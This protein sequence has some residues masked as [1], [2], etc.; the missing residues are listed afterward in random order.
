MR[1]DGKV[2]IYEFSVCVMFLYTYTA[3]FTSHSYVNCYLLLR[4]RCVLVGVGSCL[5]E[6]L[7]IFI[8]SL[9]QM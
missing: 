1:T 3:R 9:T 6:S 8:L 2:D 5:E 7:P 4:Q